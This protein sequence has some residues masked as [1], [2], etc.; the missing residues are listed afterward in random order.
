MSLAW[1][2]ALAMALDAICGEPR[3]LW[4]RLPHPA[5]LMGRLVGVLDAKLNR[6]PAAR[7]AGVVTLLILITV[8]GTIGWTLSQAG[9]LVAAL[10]AAILLAQKSLIDHVRA[11]ADG[12]RTSLGD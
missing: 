2:F 5:V 12:L 8:A 9:G 11:V 4:S 1:I 3:W 10:G 7:A 6:P